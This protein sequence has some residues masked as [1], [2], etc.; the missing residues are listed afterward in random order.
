[1]TKLNNINNLEHRF[2]VGTIYKPVRN[3]KQTYTVIDQMTVS[4]QYN[5][6]TSIHYHALYTAGGG[7]YIKRDVREEDIEKGLLNL[8]LNNFEFIPSW[9]SESQSNYYY[10]IDDINNRFPSRE[11]ALQDYIENGKSE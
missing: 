10:Y 9:H 4:N 11:E 5:E 3:R 7:T 6:V 1:M 8:T 2:A